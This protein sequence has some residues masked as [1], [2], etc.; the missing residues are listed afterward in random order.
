MLGLEPTIRMAGFPFQSHA[1]HPHSIPVIQRAELV[2]A[3][4]VWS[5]EVTCHSPDDRI[6]FLDPFGIQ[7]VTADG[8]FPYPRLEFLHG[9]GTHLGRVAG[10]RE[11]EKGE[12]LP[13]G[14]DFGLLGTE[15]QAELFNELLDRLPCLLRLVF[16]LAEHNEI[17][18]VSHESIAESFEMPVEEV[19]RDIRQQGRKDAG[20]NVAKN[21]PSFDTVIP[22]SRLKPRYG[23]GSTF[24]QDL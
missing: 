12:P 24:G 21:W 5:P 18:G 2:H 1:P 3:R 8:Q 15:R 11:S 19:Q 20:N 7:V 6:Q 14:G 16:C 17:I 10:H 9:F 4:R 22:R 23:Q 13:E